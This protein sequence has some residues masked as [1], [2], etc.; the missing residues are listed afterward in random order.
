M[1]KLAAVFACG[2]SVLFADSAQK[3]LIQAPSLLGPEVTKLDW[4]TRA[5]NAADVDR[6]GLQDL[7]L[8]NNDHARIEILLQKGDRP[9]KPE[10]R[11]VLNANRWDP[12]F[13]D[14]SFVKENVVTGTSMY[15]LAV[16]DFNNDGLADFVYTSK[17]EGLAIIFQDETG[18]SWTEKQY[19][20]ELEALPWAST[21]KVADLN[22][23]GLDDLIAFGVGRMLIYI[24]DQREGFVEPQ[25]L[26]LSS[27]SFYAIEVNDLNDDGLLDIVYQAPNSERS[28]R[29][30]MQYA[31]GGFGPEL[32]FDMNVASGYVK[33]LQLPHA[34]RMHYAYIHAQ[35]RTVNTVQL[36][37]SDKEKKGERELFPQIYGTGNVSEDSTYAVADYNGDGELDLIVADTNDARVWFYEQAKEGTWTEGVDY[38]SLAGI[39]SM[40]SIQLGERKRERGLVLLSR[41]EKLIGISRFNQDD[42]LVFPKTLSLEGEPEAFAVGNLDGDAAGVEELLVVESRKRDFFLTQLQYDAATKGFVTIAS[43][44]L[45]GVKRAPRSI[46]FFDFDQDG[47]D[48]AFLI[49]PR[50]AARIY[51]LNEASEWQE[52]ATESAMRKSLLDDLELSQIGYGDINGDNIDE[53]L[54]GGKGFVRT[55]VL[56]KQ[57]DLEVV[58]QFNSRRGDDV[59]SIPLILD[60]DDDGQD[61]VVLYV[62][63][64][65][66]LQVLEKDEQGVFR[67]NRSFDVGKIEAV[68]SFPIRKSQRIPKTGQP[69]RAKFATYISHLLVLGKETFWMLPLQSNG[70]VVDAK[71]SYETD[72]EDVVHGQIQAGDLDSDGWDEILLIDGI[73]HVLEILKFDVENE[74]WQSV[75]HFVVFDENMHY[76]GRKGAPLEPREILVG[77]FT[78]DGKE[79]FVLLVHDRILLYPQG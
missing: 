41:D 46:Q 22:Q 20:D 37:E 18:N 59:V 68:A 1:I 57:G 5:L 60:F 77:D 61:E 67:Y 19:F 53:L 17:T 44:E 3:N 15:A 56:N 29:A 7:I 38:P 47:K 76:S 63:E 65:Q 52:I 51:R 34:D 2:V 23:D 30:R 11:Q 74:D 16:G 35:T 14:N 66:A 36:V 10:Q 43:F 25:R 39:S 58:E 55:L 71:Y 24:Q 50:E 26:W 21:L 9:D 32:S 78:G 12:M 28:F 64:R 70:L 75:M 72:L 33:A 54:I 49:L 40:A 79:D 13:E 69:S 27:D 4:N 6:D 62:Q 31:S 73:N 48:E 8:I 45:E 42:R